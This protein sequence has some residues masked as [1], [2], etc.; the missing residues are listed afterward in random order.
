MR[1]I[2]QGIVPELMRVVQ[3]ECRHC[4]ALFEFHVAEA[5]LVEDRRDGDYH[6]IKCPCC[7]E[8]VRKAV[9]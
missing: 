8:L 4:K 6:E 7:S 1:I 3:A 2:R 9:K 5:F